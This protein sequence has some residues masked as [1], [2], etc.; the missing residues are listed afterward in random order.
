M[1]LLSV[2]PIAKGITKDQ[3][4][5]FTTKDTVPGE[6]VFVPLRKKVVPA[7]VLESTK[8]EN[9]KTK[10]K[11]STFAMK[12][13]DG[14]H[15]KIFLLPQF[16]DASTNT[17]LFF[18]STVGAVLHQVVPKILFDNVDNLP[19]PIV[20]QKDN[21]ARLGCEKLIL[22]ADEELRF[23][24]FKGIVREE[25]ARNNSVFIS[26]P[27]IREAERIESELQK[28]IEPYVFVLHSEIS[29][30]ELAMRIEGILKSKH[31][32]LI[33]GTPSFL[34]VPRCDVGTIIVEHESARSYKRQTRPYIN[35]R[36][37]AELYAETL[38]A[39][40]IFADMPLSIDTH[41][42]HK[43]NGYGELKSARTSVAE[44]ADQY[45]VDMRVT[46]EGAVNFSAISSELLE[47]I[48]KA[49]KNSQNTFLFNVRRGIAPTTV[50]E[51]CGSIVVCSKCESPVVL[52]KSGNKNV[53][54]CHACSSVRSAK[55]RCHTCS[56]W[57]LKALGIG[58]TRVKEEL[59]SHFA[60]GKIFSIDS[61]S[62]K[63]YN[64]AKK[65][66]QDFYNTRGAILVGTELSLSFINQPVEVVGIVS[67][68][69]LLSIPDAKIHE[70][71]FSLVLKTRA[72]AIGSFFLQTRQP[73]LP[74]IQ[75]ALKGNIS[76]FYE[77]EILMRRRFDYPPFSV[78]IK[79]SSFGIPKKAVAELEYVESF[80]KNYDFAIY[81]G[82][83]PIGSGKFALNGLLKIPSHKWP[84][85]DLVNL[86][87]SL[88][89]YLS[90]NVLPTSTL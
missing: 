10:I 38:G 15:G 2:S 83:T 30:K 58:V 78:L 57:K 67:L 20:T 82:F 19:S 11:Q 53:F 28:G 85:P 43:R 8:I 62:T 3:L 14:R 60:E 73:L 12:K 46:K 48:N 27:T 75:Y 86:L 23:S 21:V 7:I 77:K 9:L 33:I 49:H 47:T 22:E 17:A 18:A 36:I 25:F 56:S 79:I 4:S 5:Y 89:P 16:V 72:L 54:L 64:R 41:Y 35:M 70:H 74:V 63:T 71:L 31:P 84:D 50:C 1:R 76:G 51:D 59:K 87:R 40:I 34:S 69:S 68:D 55:E 80:L 6:L 39:R 66:A 90:V 42:R 52:H 45:V 32:V 37:F 81:P 24:N 13:V 44:S 65:V 61:D 29:K 26:I 88:P